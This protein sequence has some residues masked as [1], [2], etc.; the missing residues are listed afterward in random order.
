LLHRF[1][2]KHFANKKN[3]PNKEKIHI[4]I[5]KTYAIPTFA[6]SVIFPQS[7]FPFPKL[8]NSF[9]YKQTSRFRIEMR[10]RMNVVLLAKADR[11]MLL[12]YINANKTLSTKINTLSLNHAH[13][14][15]K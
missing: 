2:I 14:K 11:V 4:I 3:T 6:P 13:T 12:Y 15:I 5:Q 1:E 7:N 9:V 10:M 8:A